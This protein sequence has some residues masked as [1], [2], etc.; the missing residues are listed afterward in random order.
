M[1]WIMLGGALWVLLLLAGWIVLD[2]GL[3]ST[4]T[5]ERTEGD[6]R[7]PGRVRTRPQPPDAKMIRDRKDNR[8][9]D[10]IR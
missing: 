2:N 7:R 6:R 5:V 1:P 8:Q 10:V 4:E 9:K 3:R